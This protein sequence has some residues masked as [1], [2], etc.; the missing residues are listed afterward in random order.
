MLAV[1][2]ENH[3][4]VSFTKMAMRRVTTA[5]PTIIFV[6]G[7]SMGSCNNIKP[8]SQQVENLCRKEKTLYISKTTNYYLQTRQSKS[9]HKFGVDENFKF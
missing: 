2:L 7:F 4:G 1:N 8:E 3:C 9:N 6:T 5:T